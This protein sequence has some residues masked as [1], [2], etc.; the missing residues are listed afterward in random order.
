VQHIH[1]IR[2]FDRKVKTFPSQ[3]GV[4]RRLTVTLQFVAKDRAVVDTSAPATVE[5]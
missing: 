5:S 2:F 1:A 3:I 4:F